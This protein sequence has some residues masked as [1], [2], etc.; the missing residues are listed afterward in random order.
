MFLAHPHH[1]FCS[2]SISDET[3]EDFSLHWISTS[4]SKTWYSFNYYPFL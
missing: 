3:F 2:F 1:R 4:Y